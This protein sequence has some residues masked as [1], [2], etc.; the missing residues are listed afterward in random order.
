MNKRIYYGALAVCATLASCS[1]E[2]P[3]DPGKGGN[4]EENYLSVN[5]VSPAGTRADE[6]YE[7]GTADENKAETA[8]FLFFDENG[9]STQTP[10][11]VNLDWSTN[12]STNPQVERISNATV[13][14]AGSKEPSQMI[15]V[16]N[17]PAGYYS[18]VNGISA[19]AVRALRKRYDAHDSGKFIMTNSVYV[20]TKDKDGVD[21]SEDKYYEVFTTDIKGKAQATEAEA[22]KPENTVDVYVER[23]VSKIRT[24]GIKTTGDDKFVKDGQKIKI[25]GEEVEYIPVIEGIEIANVAKS[26][27]LIKSINGWK[28]W[29]WS[30][31]GGSKFAWND[32]ANKRC[33]WTS[34]PTELEFD[35]LSWNA[36]SNPT[37]EGG[38]PNSDY[39]DPTKGQTFYVLPNTHPSINTSVLV[40]ATLKKKNAD[41]TAGEPLEFLYWGGNYYAVGDDNPRNNDGTENKNYK[42]FLSQY[43][44]ILTNLGYRIQYQESSGIDKRRDIKASDLRWIT[45]EEQLANTKRAN[46]YNFDAH[47][48]TA[49]IEQDLIWEFIEEAKA[50]DGVRSSST[51]FVKLNSN[52]EPEAATFEAANQK[53]REKVNRVWMWTGGRC[54]YYVDINHFGPKTATTDFS[55]GLIR[56][57]I[58]DLTLN[59]LMGIGTPVFNPDEIIIPNK[60]SDKLWYLAAK[61][62]ILKWRLVK[63]TV[64]FTGVEK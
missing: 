32:P 12:T 7:N 25:D 57:H 27:F 47:E 39:N 8:V 9:N 26:T 61:L 43:A 63:Q 6:D 19:D 36:I 49:C 24:S 4:G 18:S 20:E 33:Y 52:G 46:P 50:G 31:G 56:N 13:V 51:K 23:V 44:L 11:T 3:I 10:Q 38:A 40:T 48:T 17:P 30:T 41:G 64:D 34:T 28:S 21:L 37:L 42:G 62:N 22:K 2:D 55:H 29:D 60:P 15:V 5:I 59:S 16:L 14:I 58:Y 1:N 54:Y 35:N 53:L 45:K